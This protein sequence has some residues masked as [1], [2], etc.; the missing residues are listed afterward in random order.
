MI[1]SLAR[2]LAFL[3]YEMTAGRQRAVFPL[4]VTGKDTQR[5][6]LH[7]EKKFRRPSHGGLMPTNRLLNTPPLLSVDFG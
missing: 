1:G 4:F 5:A 6:K 2:F 3:F 7:G